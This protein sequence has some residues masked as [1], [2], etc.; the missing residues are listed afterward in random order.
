MRGEQSAFAFKLSTLNR[1][2][3]QGAGGPGPGGRSRGAGAGGPEPGGRGGRGRGAGG[4]APGGRGRGGRG[5]ESFFLPLFVQN[6]TNSHL[7]FRFLLFKN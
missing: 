5:L 1:K 3:M 4:P 7:I 6:C 2:K